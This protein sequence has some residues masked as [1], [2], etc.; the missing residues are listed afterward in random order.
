MEN[1]LERLKM[2]FPYGNC[3]SDITKLMV[4]LHTLH[5][6]KSTANVVVIL[7]DRYFDASYL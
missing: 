6:H 4:G 1:I 7:K 5:A 3:F 2:K